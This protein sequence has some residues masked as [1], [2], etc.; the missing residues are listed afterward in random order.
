M[1]GRPK[2]STRSAQHEG[3]PAMDGPAAEAGPHMDLVLRAQGNPARWQADLLRCSTSEPQHFESLGE[4][5]HFL[6]RL[7]PA[8][9]A[10]SGIR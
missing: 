1:P 9:S 6:S 2:G 3:S 7:D 8:P 5:I 10:P 4:L